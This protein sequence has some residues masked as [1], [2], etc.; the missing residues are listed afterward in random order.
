MPIAADAQSRRYRRCVDHRAIRRAAR[1]V[2]V[3]ALVIGSSACGAGSD[4]PGGNDDL[5]PEFRAVCGKPG[6]TVAIT[7][8]SG[9][10]RRGDCDLRGVTQTVDRLGG[11]GGAVVPADGEGVGNSGGLVISTAPN[12]DVTYRFEASP[13]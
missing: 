4:K 9:T 13:R 2:G 8:T 6:S 12:G 3:A 5:P 1:A 10:V 11:V 7:A